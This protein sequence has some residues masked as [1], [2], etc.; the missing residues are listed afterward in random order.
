MWLGIVERGWL[1]TWSSLRMEKKKKDG[2]FQGYKRFTPVTVGRG[3]S[4]R[5][6][7]M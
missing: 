6:I 2:W 1:E 4:Y 3:W 7:W 5:M